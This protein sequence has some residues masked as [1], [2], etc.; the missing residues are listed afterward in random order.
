[1]CSCSQMWNFHLILTEGSSHNNKPKW[2]SGQCCTYSSYSDFPM[3]RQASCKVCYHR[4]VIGKQ[5][6]EPP[7]LRLIFDRLACS[8]RGADGLSWFAAGCISACA[9]FKQKMCWFFL[10]CRE[11]TMNYDCSAIKSALNPVGW[12]LNEHWHPAPKIGEERL[13]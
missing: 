8:T 2:S 7:F 11:V 10:S 1:M 6:Q 12:T 9:V 3:S 13:L 5:F 4:T